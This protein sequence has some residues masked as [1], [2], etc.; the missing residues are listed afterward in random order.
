L[1]RTWPRNPDAAINVEVRMLFESASGDVEEDLAICAG[2][3]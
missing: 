2:L 1:Q 3:G